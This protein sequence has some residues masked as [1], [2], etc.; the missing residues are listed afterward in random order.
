MDV[1]LAGTI[2]D[3]IVDGP[4]LR[5]VIFFQGCLHNCPNC[6]NQDTHSIE[7]NKL[8][9]IDDLINQIES[10]PL[11]KK[12]TI[13]GGEPF[14][15][16]DVLLEL[17]QKLKNYHLWIYTGYTKEELEEMNYTKVFNYIEALVDGPFIENEKTLDSPYIGSKN[18]KIYYFK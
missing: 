8:V 3:S 6:H 9:N 2:E 4:G 17:C 11:A 15:Q 18:Q 1:N 12:V 7:I 10:N 14:L 5:F 13:S 16:Y